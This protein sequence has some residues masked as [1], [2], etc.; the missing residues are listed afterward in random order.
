[1]RNATHTRARAEGGAAASPAASNVTPRSGRRMKA[2][3]ADEL[4]LA[5]TDAL[6]HILQYEREYE[7]EY[8]RGF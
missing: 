4:A 2:A 8:Q 3:P 5:M 6:E 1:M 7:R